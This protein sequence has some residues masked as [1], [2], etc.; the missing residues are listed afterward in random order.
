MRER[1]PPSISWLHAALGA[2]VALLFAE[3]AGAGVASIAGCAVGGFVAAR[4]AGK[5]GLFQGAATATGFIIIAA[6][7]D[8]I[9][10]TPL[11]P[12]DTTVLIVLDVLHLAAGAAGGW[13]AIRS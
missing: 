11:L 2:I 3:V 8:T 10:P 4:L 6:L 13:L 5:F 9:S 7:L 1:T 12:G